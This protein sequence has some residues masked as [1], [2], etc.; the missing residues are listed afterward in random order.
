MILLPGHNKPT[1]VTYEVIYGLAIVEG[2]MIL[3]QASGNGRVEAL[4]IG[5]E[6]S[7]FVLC[8]LSSVASSAAPCRRELMLQLL[9]G[10][11]TRILT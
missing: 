5:I 2:A 4:G 1:L 9:I 6:G 10:K 8:R 7:R 3:G 11:R